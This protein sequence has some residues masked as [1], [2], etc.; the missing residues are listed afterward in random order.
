MISIGLQQLTNQIQGSYSIMETKTHE[1][2]C[3]MGAYLLYKAYKMFLLEGEKEI[4]CNDMKQKMK[5]AIGPQKLG[6]G[7]YNL[8]ANHL[9]DLT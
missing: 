6:T 2:K 9:K 4:S 3:E 1:Q 8:S 5:K 7:D